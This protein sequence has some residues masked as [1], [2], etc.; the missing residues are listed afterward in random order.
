M[1]VVGAGQAGLALGYYLD[2]L[3]VSFRLLDSSDRVGA[4]WSQRWDSLT[5]FTPRRYS[6]LPGLELPGDTWSYAGKDEVADYLKDYAHHFALPVQTGS[7]ATR[8]SRVDGKFLL[9]LATGEQI[10][11]RQVVIATGA[12]GKAFTPSLAD[13]L[14]ADIT[15]L[16]A[17]KYRNPNMLP[18]NVA[19]VGGGNS[20][21]QIAHEL[22]QAG[23]RVALSEGAQLPTLP[24][25]LL[26]RD[27]F[28]WLTSTRLIHAPGDS[29]TGR[30]M[31]AN[32]PII[33]TP[34]RMLQDA[35]VKFCPR[36]VSA[37]GNRLLFAD[38]E[39]VDV[40]A[41]IWATGYKHDDRWIEIPG[42]LDA[43]GVLAQEDGATAI[44][45]LYVLGRSWQRDRGSALLGYVHRD[46]ERL[47]RRVEA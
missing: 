1:A 26:G 6:S 9:D 31:R 14:D 33:G 5:L 19:V 20:G 25:R 18:E 8:L 21:F 22:A 24:Q 40:E 46:A 17:E 13:S 16:H 28:W 39:H 30:R 4:S 11:S 36:T 29:R 23:K 43:H 47:A 44:P 37:K 10:V 12:F 27:L 7:R 45:G 34:R 35:G 2:R 41:V 32:E 38:G 42:A 3:G 15:Q